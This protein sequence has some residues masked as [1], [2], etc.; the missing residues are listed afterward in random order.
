MTF[1]VAETL[2]PQVETMCLRHVEKIKYLQQSWIFAKTPTLRSKWK[3][4]IEPMGGKSWH[5]SLLA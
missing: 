3:E 4:T 5:T 1:T 2:G